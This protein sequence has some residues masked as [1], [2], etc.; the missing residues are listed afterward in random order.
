[1]AIRWMGIEMPTVRVFPNIIMMVILVATSAGLLSNNS[2]QEKFSLLKSPVLLWICGFF[3]LGVLIAAPQLH[4]YEQSI[5]LS[6]QWLEI[7]SSV[8]FLFLAVIS[9]F[10]IFIKLGTLLG[11]LFNDLPPLNAYATNLMGSIAGTA[12]FSIISC[13]AAPPY[14]WL[15][16]AGVIL[17]IVSKKPLH[18]LLAFLFSALAFSF[19]HTSYWSPYSKL[20]VLPLKVNNPIL[21]KDSFMV[22]SNNYYFHL[23][24]NTFSTPLLR[25]FVST[26]KKT[27]NNFAS[28]LAKLY[29][30]WLE[31]PYEC[32]PCA[33][34]VLILGAGSGNDAAFAL[35]QNVSHIDAVEIDPIICNFGKTKHPNHPYLDKR[36]SLHNEDAR[37]FLRYAKNKYDLIEFAF[38]DPG[39]TLCSSSFL[40]VDSYVYT[41]ES[42]MAVLRCL[43]PQGLASIAFAPDQQN[44][45]TAK[46]YNTIKAAW[47][48][49]PITIINKS[50]KDVLLLFGPGLSEE[51]VASIIKNSPDL[52]IWTPSVKQ[53]SAPAVTDQWPF[54]YTF[55][56]NNAVALYLAILFALVILP[57]LVIFMSQKKDG[58]IYETGNMFLLGLAFMLIE[59]KSIVQLSLLFGATWIVSAAVIAM[60][61][62]LALVAN[63]I[64]QKNKQMPLQYLYA[65]LTLAIFFDYFF[66][67]PQATDWHPLL[68]TF[69]SILI[70]CLP[71]LFSG[72]IFS[73]CFRNAKNPSSYL[74][75]PA[76]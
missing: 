61:L 24:V 42:I 20:D 70:T 33:D 59:T 8:G 64:V 74:V 12:T 44:N 40:R 18:L 1:M 27:D 10:V 76:K 60:V 55:F 31:I 66:S 28:Q 11:P 6:N 68:M 75:H 4:L 17:F 34:S 14:I 56:D 30:T 2:K 38:L 48:R 67:V 37:T 29:F 32:A 43:K 16:I 19:N 35:S 39:S 53:I 3:I 46:I 45:I 51:K 71:I 21:T 62:F 13:F 50:R 41:E 63:L 49:P 47:G 9:L 58:N 23:A 69:I 73:T 25:S 5:H 26:I 22:N 54:L 36:V 65:V 57:A 7:V 52:G 15:L 72:M